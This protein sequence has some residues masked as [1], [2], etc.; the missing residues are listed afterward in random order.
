MGF[1]IHPLFLRRLGIWKLSS[2]LLG[3]LRRRRHRAGRRRLGWLLGIP[4]AFLVTRLPLIPGR[5][6]GITI[7]SLILI[8]VRRLIRRPS[9]VRRRDLP[10]LGMPA[11]LILALPIGI[12]LR[13]LMVRRLPAGIPH[14]RR[15]LGAGLENAGL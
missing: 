4:A 12:I 2:L 14:R 3:R 11:S 1:L 10:L 15:R 13:R 7:G 9:I 8:G 5:L 6:A